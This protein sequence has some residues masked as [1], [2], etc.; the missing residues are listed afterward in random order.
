[1]IV[2]HNVFADSLVL[3]LGYPVCPDGRRIPGGIT[4]MTDSLLQL[5]GPV[6]HMGQCLEVCITLFL[7]REILITFHSW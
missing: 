7:L 6:C 4:A 3:T 1:M 2:V 5:R